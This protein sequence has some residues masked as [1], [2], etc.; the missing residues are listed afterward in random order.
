MLEMK[1][2][3]DNYGIEQVII[4]G[5]NAGVD[6]FFICHDPEL[7]DRAI[8][9]LIKAAERD[10]VPPSRIDDANWRIDEIVKRFYQPPADREMLKV[11]GC[12]EHRSIAEQ[13]EA[14]AEKAAAQDPTE[15]WRSSE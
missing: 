5:A 13:V 12:D 9:I 15:S 4:R 6:L 3:A 7:Q 1:A 14:L 8:D 10:E 11:V 2:I